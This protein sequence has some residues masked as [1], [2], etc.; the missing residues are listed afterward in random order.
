M[1]IQFIERHA[2][3]PFL[4]YLP[5]SM[6]HVPIFASEAFAGKSGAGP[7]GDVVMEV[8]WS[9]G[10]ILDAIRNNGVDENTLVIFTADNGPW[11]S[12]GN[13]A[14]TAGPLR[15]G[16]G[17]AFEGGV[18][19]PFLARWPGVVPAGRVVRASLV[20]HVEHHRR[21]RTA[22]RSPGRRISLS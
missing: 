11:L 18:R 21:P 1:K 8:D 9:V 5:H 2:T 3:Q 6:V 14:G 22:D 15:E 19:V 17:T 7:F 4:L 13:H 10:Q 12:Y 16:K 20:D